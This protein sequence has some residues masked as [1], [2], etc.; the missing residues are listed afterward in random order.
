[1]DSRLSVTGPTRA[2]AFA[3]NLMRRKITGI[4]FVCLGLLSVAIGLVALVM[5]VSDVLIRGLPVLDWQFLTSFDSR[6]PERAGI[7]AAVAGT[8][9]MMVFTILIAVPLGVGAAIYLEEYGGDNRLT[10]FIEINISNLAGVP[11]IIFGLPGLQL[12]VR[13]MGLDRSVL[14]GSLTMAILVL[15]IVIV[16][17]REAIRAVPPSLREASLALGATRWQTTWHHV[18][19]Y[20]FSGILTGNILASSRAIGETAPLIAI[21]ALTYIPFVPE[22]PLDR[23]TALPIQIFNKLASRTL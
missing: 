4:L 21:G 5:L 22:N 8:A 7:F 3:G 9:Y 20:A 14:A 15:P 23:F 12:F 10:R 16:A 17:A 2:E 1:M 13:W 11:S 6:F 18:L 19:P